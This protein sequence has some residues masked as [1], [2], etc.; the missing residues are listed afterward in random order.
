M[1]S[2]PRLSPE[3]RLQI[4]EHTWPARVIEAASHA[5]K[6]AG[7]QRNATYWHDWLVVEVL[8]REAEALLTP[9]VAPPPRERKK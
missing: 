1:P 4:W 2:F 8:R 5:E 9:A 6:L 3:L 7:Y